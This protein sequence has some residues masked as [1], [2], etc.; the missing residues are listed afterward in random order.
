MQRKIIVCA[1]PAITLSQIPAE[2]A[3]AIGS[4]L[5]EVDASLDDVSAAGA[6]LDTFACTVAISLPENFQVDALDGATL[7]PLA[8]SDG[9]ESHT[10]DDQATFVARLCDS[11]QASDIRAALA[12]LAPGQ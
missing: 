7:A 4:Y 9:A 8:Q 11:T 6:A 5:F 12:A 3:A 10:L 2:D 1:Q